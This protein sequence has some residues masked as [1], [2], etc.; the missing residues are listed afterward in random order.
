MTTSLAALMPI[1]VLNI[2]VSQT[3]TGGSTGS[4][5]G[6]SE[7]TCVPIWRLWGKFTSRLI[8]SRLLIEFNAMQLSAGL[9]AVLSFWRPLEF[10]RLWPP[11]SQQWKVKK[12]YSHP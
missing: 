8:D 6:A 4:L 9:K 7:H 5:L 12:S 1:Y 2:S 11:A 3:G 10:E